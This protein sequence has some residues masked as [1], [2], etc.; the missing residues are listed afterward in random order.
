MREKGGGKQ[1]KDI[2][3]CMRKSV[4]VDDGQFP[5]VWLIEELLLIFLVLTCMHVL[6][7]LSVPSSDN[8]LASAGGTL[9]F[10]LF[11]L[12]QQCSI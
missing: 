6:H 4:K 9:R 2:R 12:I 5:R 7:W 8:S 3:V 11:V 10:R 1:K